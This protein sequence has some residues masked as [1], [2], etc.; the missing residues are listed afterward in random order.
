MSSHHNHGLPD[1]EG[2][3]CGNSLAS[4]FDVGFAL[5]IRLQP[6]ERATFG[7]KIRSDLMR[8]KD[9]HVFAFEEGDDQA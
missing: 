6:A 8:T 5:L 2:P 3:K 4:D 1:V 7:N 9:M